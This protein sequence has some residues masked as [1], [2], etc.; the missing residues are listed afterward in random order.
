MTHYYDNCEPLASGSAALLGGLMPLPLNEPSSLT[1]PTVRPGLHKRATIKSLSD[2]DASLTDIYLKT[3][4][5]CVVFGTFME[6]NPLVGLLA[7]YDIS[8]PAFSLPELF[9]LSVHHMSQK[10]KHFNLAQ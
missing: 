4:A 1:A 6:Q 7:S 9:I 3:L 10:V 5:N 8:T 2:T